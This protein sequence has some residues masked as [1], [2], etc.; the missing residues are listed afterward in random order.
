MI[1]FFALLVL[2]TESVVPNKAWI[3]AR[4]ASLNDSV[5]L[6]PL[7]APA[8]I[9]LT[10]SITNATLLRDLPDPLVWQLDDVRH[11]FRPACGATVE[12]HNRF[13]RAFVEY[14]TLH[15]KIASGQLPPR[16]V[17]VAFPPEAGTHSRLKLLVTAVLFG[18]LTDRA[19]VLS[20]V[21]TPQSDGYAHAALPELLRVP[22]F[23]WWYLP[24]K[25]SDARFQRFSAR[26]Y[27]QEDAERLTHEPEEFMCADLAA[28]AA[29]WLELHWKNDAFGAA[30]FHNPFLHARA[31][32]ML[33]A[34]DLYGPVARK[35]L[36]PH[37]LVWKRFAK[38]YRRFIARDSVRRTG[39][40]MR[41]VT[42][43]LHVVG[44]EIA[45]PADAARARAC[46]HKR[47]FKA[48]SQAPAADQ[49]VRVLRYFLSAPTVPPALLNETVKHLGAD[50][51]FRYENDDLMCK[52][53]LFQNRY[54][55][56]ERELVEEL[57]MQFSDTIL[58]PRATERS[59]HFL[60]SQRAVLY[61]DDDFCQLDDQC[62]PCFSW[63]SFDEFA[64]FDKHGP[65]PRPKQ[66][67]EACAHSLWYRW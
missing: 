66:K 25:Y 28:D 31:A 27:G 45:K 58:V 65:L 24:H 11:E 16:F 43:R 32:A 19:A 41:D 3:A 21:P 62:Q 46:V 39:K 20:W 47:G 56:E 60:F 8:L 14:V 34:D 35:I 1:F 18:M 6:G 55:G 61:D 67:E 38:L 36:R 49:S 50:R 22:G 9:A 5:E 52:P 44:V 64:C 57:L 12:Q 48:R 51:T 7:P 26:G 17:H 13:E 59:R 37:G 4:L 33:A 23:D 2:S 15:R 30:L 40:A 42:P 54:P 63:K 53:G 10:A 29:P